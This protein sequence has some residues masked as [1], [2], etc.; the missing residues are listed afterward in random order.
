MGAGWLG[1]CK[2]LKNIIGHILYMDMFSLVVL[3][4]K[5][6]VAGMMKK[7]FHI[8]H[9]GCSCGRNYIYHHHSQNSSKIEQGV[10]WLRWKKVS[11][12]YYV[13][14][15]QQHVNTTPAL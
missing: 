9:F 6:R 3:L 7:I 5:L 8:I 14:K 4:S 13:N 11:K 12:H 1:G 15:T 10:W 2:D